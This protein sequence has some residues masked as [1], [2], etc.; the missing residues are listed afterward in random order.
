M[1][2]NIF[3]SGIPIGHIQIVDAKYLSDE[4]LVHPP[5]L[6]KTYFDNLQRSFVD[7]SLSEGHK[8]TA[9]SADTVNPV[10]YLLMSP[11]LHYPLS[12]GQF[13]GEV[14]PTVRWA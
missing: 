9:K 6:G 3:E 5:L 7:L 1:R 11:H 8:D 13:Y 14:N 10:Q 2:R 12:S 4:K